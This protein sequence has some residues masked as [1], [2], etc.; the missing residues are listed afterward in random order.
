MS[1]QTVEL[2]QTN[3]HNADGVM[4]RVVKLTNAVFPIVGEHLTSKEI[5]NYIRRPGWTVIIKE[6]KQ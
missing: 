2:V 5:Q 3:V 4:Y 1:K 6:G